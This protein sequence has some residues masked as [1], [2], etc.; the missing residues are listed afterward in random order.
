M[1]EMLA[2]RLFAFLWLILVAH[3]LS[4]RGQLGLAHLDH[5]HH[6]AHHQSEP[7]GSA[8]RT[9]DE[10]PCELEAVKPAATNLDI[11]VDPEMGEL[12]FVFLRASVEISPG[13]LVTLNRA[14]IGFERDLDERLSGSL[15]L[16]PNAPPLV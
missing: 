10:K 4:D 11:S 8:D 14:L 9:S 13:P 12:A 6:H 2:H 1:P 7:E 15:T 3:C 16:S 5:H